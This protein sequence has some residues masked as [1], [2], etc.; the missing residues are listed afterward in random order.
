MKIPNWLAVLL[1]MLLVN[2]CMPAVAAQ[3]EVEPRGIIFS[4]EQIKSQK[5]VR[6]PGPYWTPGQEQIDQLERKLPAYLKYQYK[7]H[8]RHPKIDLSKYKRQYFGYSLDGKK[9]IFVNAF[10]HSFD[11]WKKTYVFVF[12]GG[13]C[14]FQATFDPETGNFLSFSVNGDA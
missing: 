3:K 9:V 6:A 2:F 4:A 5:F 11:Y 10:C 8:S 13:Q 1:A 12:D 7:N 14:F